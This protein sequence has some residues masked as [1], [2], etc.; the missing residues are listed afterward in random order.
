MK[1]NFGKGK[2]DYRSLCFYDPV[3]SMGTFS[4]LADDY[5]VISRKKARCFLLGIMPAGEEGAVPD[6]TVFFGGD[7][8]TR[9]ATAAIYAI[10]LAIA[11]DTKKHERHAYCIAGCVFIAIDDKE[12]ANIAMTKLKKLL[13]GTKVKARWK[14]AETNRKIRSPRSC[15]LDAVSR[16]SLYLAG[17]G[18]DPSAAPEGGKKQKAPK[19]EAKH[20]EADVA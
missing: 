9:D 17:K 7:K 3:T 14:Y 12:Q 18:P 16:I 15:L 8:A 19:E 1:G 6:C 10:A 4:L 13:T 5:K 2:T 11:K 20:E